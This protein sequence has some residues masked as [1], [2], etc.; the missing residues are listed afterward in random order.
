MERHRRIELE[1]W[2]RTDRQ[3]WLSCE[4]EGY[5]VGVTRR[6]V[7]QLR[8]VGDLRAGKQRNVPLGRFP[9]LLVKP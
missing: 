9:G 8:H 4:L 7:F 2:P 5:K 3:E 1:Q 6:R